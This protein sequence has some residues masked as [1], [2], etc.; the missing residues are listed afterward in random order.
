M[1]FE[2]QPTRP[3]TEIVR[4]FL[5]PDRAKITKRSNYV[6]PDEE[7]GMIVRSRGAHN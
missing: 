3:Q 7:D 6:R 5:D 2:R 4:R 1:Q